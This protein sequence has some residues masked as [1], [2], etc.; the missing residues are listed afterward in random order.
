MRAACDA[1]AWPAAA[2]MVIESYGPEV[3]AFLRAQARTE[4]DAAELFSV[5]CESLW[6]GL[7]RFRWASSLRTWSYAI[8]RHAWSHYLRDPARRRAQVALS[9]VASHELAERVRTTVPPHAQSAIKDR[10][11]ALRAELDD[12]DRTLLILRVDRGLEWRDIAQ[13]MGEPDDD[14]EAIDRRSATLR[15]RFLRLKASLREALRD[16]DDS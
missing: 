14:D 11:A 4:D 3:L 15:K 7:P 1:Q 16:G 8:A 6:N 12:D 10:L 13:I 2:T 5:Y 9:D